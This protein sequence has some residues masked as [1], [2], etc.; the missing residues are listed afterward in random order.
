MG[1]VEEEGGEGEADGEE[2]RDEDQD[3]SQ[4]PTL[5]DGN[6]PAGQ[7]VQLGKDMILL[8]DLTELYLQSFDVG[9]DSWRVW[10]PAEQVKGE[11]GEVEHVGRGE[12]I[13]SQAG[14]IT[15]QRSS[16]ILT[17]VQLPLHHPHLLRPLALAQLGQEDQK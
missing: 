2:E 4:P 15:E 7:T 13:V 3:G 9:R 16:V 6:N 17:E 11:E 12:T 14:Q 10:L 5:L 8:T 1:E